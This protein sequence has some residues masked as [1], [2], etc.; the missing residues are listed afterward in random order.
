[1][2]HSLVHG[3][4]F[5]LFPEGLEDGGILEVG[6]RYSECRCVTAQV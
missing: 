6:N 5:G 4:I 1:M 3:H 2:I